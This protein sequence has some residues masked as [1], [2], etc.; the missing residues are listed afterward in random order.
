MTNRDLQRTKLDGKL[1]ESQTWS[2]WGKK[3]ISGSWLRNHNWETES[4]VGKKLI[5]KGKSNNNGD[6]QKRVCGL[7]RWVH[8][9]VDEKCLT[10]QEKPNKRRQKRIRTKSKHTKSGKRSKKTFDKAS[11]TRRRVLEQRTGMR[12]VGWSN[13][14]NTGASKNP[15][16]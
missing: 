7:W 4:S 16:T 3:K 10:K 6:E 5:G 9:G 12:K 2:N 8:F 11:E 13:F 1:R 14:G 15:T